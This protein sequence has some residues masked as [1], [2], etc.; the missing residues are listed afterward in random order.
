[1]LRIDSI[2]RKLPLLVAPSGNFY[3]PATER[4]YTDADAIV[5]C[6]TGKGS[7]CFQ[8]VGIQEPAVLRKSKWRAGEHLLTF[9][10][11]PPGWRILE[12]RPHCTPT[13]LTPEQAVSA[14]EAHVSKGRN[15]GG[16]HY[17][18]GCSCEAPKGK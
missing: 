6:L 15:A 14:L 1:M 5:S 11:F 9:N 10:T 17:A 8:Q 12:A 18:E 3:T 4:G 16:H 13:A 2:H 7:Y